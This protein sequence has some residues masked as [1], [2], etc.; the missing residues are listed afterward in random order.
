M[1]EVRIHGQGDGGYG[2][3]QH[4][5][6][7]QENVGDSSARL[8]DFRRRRPRGHEGRVKIRGIG[9]HIFGWDGK[10]EF[11]CACP[12]NPTTLV[13]GV[14]SSSQLYIIAIIR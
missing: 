3:M 9:Q 5:R 10:F 1:D 4:Q 6:G 2:R 12:K 13:V 8:G 7:I 14:V 11:I